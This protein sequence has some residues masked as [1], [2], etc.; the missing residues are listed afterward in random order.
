[1]VTW[2]WDCLFPI[3]CVGCHCYDRWLCASCLALLSTPG[4]TTGTR[5]GRPYIRTLYWLGDYHHPIL[6]ASIHGLKY[7]GWKGLAQPLARGLA[8]ILTG[9]YDAVIATPLHHRRER[10]RGFNQAQLLAQAFPWQ[11][12]SAL[13]RY[14]WTEPQAQLNR[15]QRQINIKQAFRLAMT[16]NHLADKTIL[17]IDDVFTTGATTETCATLLQAAGCRAIDVAVLARD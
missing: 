7:E 9:S 12:W 10:E 13:E 8:G 11:T 5:I 15:Q 3:Q 14:R 4:Y 2:L 6:R 17:L 16:P 1:M